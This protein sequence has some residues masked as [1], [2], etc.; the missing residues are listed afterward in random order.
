VD[1]HGEHSAE[2]TLRSPQT[3]E[4]AAW[5]V[6]DITA[7]SRPER[8]VSFQFVQIPLPLADSASTNAGQSGLLFAV[9][10]AVSSQAGQLTIGYSRLQGKTWGATRWTTMDTDDRGEALLD[11]LP[12]GS[13]RLQLTF[14]PRD[15]RGNLAGSVALKTAASGVVIAP[16]KTPRLELQRR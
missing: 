4:S 11:G 14:R 10:S 6:W 13:Y 1:E 9:P 8:R 2:F 3:V 15:G 16:G 12:P 5:L 7:H